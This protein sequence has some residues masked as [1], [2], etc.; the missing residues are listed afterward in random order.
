MPEFMS[1]EQATKYLGFKSQK[2]LKNYIREGLPVIMIGRS[3]RISKKA[4]DE[5]MNAHTV[6]AAQNKQ[7]GD[8]E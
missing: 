5:F 8:K 6:V 2:S 7:G 1:L 4:I 3:K